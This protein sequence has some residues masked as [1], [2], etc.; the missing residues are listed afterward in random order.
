MGN[1]ATI[2]ITNVKP[3]IYLHWNGGRGKVQ[4]FINEALRRHNTNYHS[5]TSE[6]LTINCPHRFMSDLYGV[7]R[8]FNNFATSRGFSRDN[9]SIYLQ[10]SKEDTDNG[11]YTVSQDGTLSGGRA[12]ESLKHTKEDTEALAKFFEA[13][14]SH[15][16][17]FKLPK[18]DASE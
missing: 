10:D 3:F 2:Q 9:A 5:G 15:F 7:V 1:R 4:A 17:A 6:T 14:E 12:T 16:K 11:H 18:D 13:L 8:D